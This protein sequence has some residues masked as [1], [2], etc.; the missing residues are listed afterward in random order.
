MKIFT[1]ILALCMALLILSTSAYAYSSKSA[2]YLGVVPEEISDTTVVTREYLA[3]SLTKLVLGDA[4]LEP[5]DTVYAD[6]TKDNPFSGYINHVSDLGLMTG[7]GD[8]YFRPEEP[9][10][11]T[12]VM[13]T[14][15]K[16]LGYEPMAEYKGGWPNGYTNVAQ[17]LK[18]Y[19]GI[20]VTKKELTFA[21]LKE[22]FANVLDTDMPGEVLYTED[23]TLSSAIT[24]RGD[25]GTYGENR[26]GFNVYNV[27]ITEMDYEIKKARVTFTENSADGKYHIGDTALIAVWD[28]VNIA[29]YEKLPSE[30]VV[31]D[32]KLIID[33]IPEEGYEVKYGVV[34]SVN[35][36]F[37]DLSYGIRHINAITLADDKEDYKFASDC[38]F[39]LNDSAVSGTIR[40]LDSYVR[41][42]EKDEEIICLST[43]NLTRGGIITEPGSFNL[44][45]KLGNVEKRLSKLAEY[46]EM[47]VLIDGEVR[48]YRELRKGM[49]F[50][51][52]KEEETLIIIATEISVSDIFEGIDT[53]AN[54]MH[55]GNV[56]VPYVSDIYV[57]EDGE[58]YLSGE[59]ALMQYC[60]ADVTAVLDI[61]GRVMHVSVNDEALSTNTFAAFII[62]FQNQTSVL[63]PASKNVQL[64]NADIPGGEPQVYALSKALSNNST[65]IAELEQNMLDRFDL[66]TDSNGVP[67]AG[68]YKLYET[69]YE[70]KVNSKNEI[71]SLDRLKDYEGF[72][73][74]TWSAGWKG[75][76]DSGYL[77]V[78]LNKNSY[79]PDATDSLRKLYID[80]TVPVLCAFYDGK[81][82]K[83][84]CVTYKEIMGTEG[85]GTLHL[86]FYGSDIFPEVRLLLL[87]GNMD[88]LSAGSGGRTG[89]VDRCG[90]IL[91]SEGEEVDSV[92]IDGVTYQ[93]SDN[94]PIKTA[95]KNDFVVYAVSVFDKTIA[96]I[97]STMNIN[98]ANGVMGEKVYYNGIIDKADKL[99]VVLQGNVNGSHCFYYTRGSIKFYGIDEDGR[100]I[101]GYSYQD[102]EPG[103]E[104]IVELSQDKNNA[105]SASKVFVK[106]NN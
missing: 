52:Y 46:K 77:M 69:L 58:S 49:S 74:A 89:I 4:K 15:V 39:Y 22:I 43:W 83:F 91:N 92:T 51:F 66:E 70:A 18:L 37:A 3:Y 81:E 17:T 95:Q 27:R 64:I 19:S 94:S 5:V 34:D 84:E 30:I 41:I 53:I 76:N 38:E 1:K 16:L 13:K 79:N 23:G 86:K 65:F 54:E 57:T 14:V 72:E 59:N 63:E 10:T 2:D 29:L 45:Y 80:S 55:I 25:N 56:T 82:F 40:L 48:T 104:V 67:Q 9:V 33:I 20:D 28:G 47:K 36:S 31:Y 35:N 73:G 50:H 8:G 61:F 68:R 11:L 44:T 93:I 42:V 85:D 24:T 90:R 97:T 60:G 12:A 102:L 32:D 98:N 75:F 78:N 62:G 87:L 105:Y 96:T 100:L 101:D 103:K 6:V 88:T 7:S 21:D 26:L 106:E 71:I 99:K